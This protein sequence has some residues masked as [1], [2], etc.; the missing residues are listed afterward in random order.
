[1]STY[2]FLGHE[3]ILLGTD[4]PHQISDMENAV[5]RVKKLGISD[6]E[7]AKILGENASVLLKL[8]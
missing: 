6:M 3:K 2:S 4:Y 7:K 1:M 5:N 8:K